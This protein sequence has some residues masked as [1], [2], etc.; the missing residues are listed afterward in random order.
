MLDKDALREFIIF[1]IHRNIVNLYKRYISLTE[2]L[3]DEHSRF[4]KKLE[5]HIPPEELKQLDYFSDKKY[6]YVRKKILDIGNE[7]A[8]DL[9]KIID[10]LDIDLNKE[11]IGQFK[12][13][14]SYDANLIKKGKS[15]ENISLKFSQDK[16]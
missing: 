16:L 6:S 11:K 12:E 9:T 1:Q 2:D 4:I 15:L 7:S 13:T 3:R 5:A 14:Y 10:S 8:R